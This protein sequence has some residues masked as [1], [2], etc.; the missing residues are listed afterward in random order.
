MNFTLSPFRI[1]PFSTLK[2]AMMPRKELNTESNIHACKGASGS[3]TGGG[4][5]STMARSAER[6]VGKECVSKLRSRWSPCNK[7]QKQ[8]RQQQM[9]HD[10]FLQNNERA[11]KTS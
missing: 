10:R 6:R 11:L 3:P 4:T 2:Y 8:T 5:R 7:K 9:R 1:S